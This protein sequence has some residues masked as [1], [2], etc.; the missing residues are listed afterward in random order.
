MRWLIFYFSATKN[1]LRL[2]NFAKEVLT[3]RFDEV[4]L[5]NIEQFVYL[6]ENKL[7][8][9]LPEE[10][11]QKID[12]CDKL[13]FAYPIHAFNAPEIV[14]KWVNSIPFRSNKKSYFILKTAG[15]PMTLNDGS[16]RKI[17]QHLLK[18]NYL[19][20]NE[21][22]YV[23][24]YYIM[25]RHASQVAVKMDQTMKKT[26]PLDLEVIR[27][28]IETKEKVSIGTKVVSSLLRIEQPG[29]H[30]LGK[31]FKVDLTKCI[32][33]GKCLSHCPT[34]NI[35]KVDDKIVFH[36]RC[37]ICMR[38][39]AFCPAKAISIGIMNSWKVEGEYDFSSLVEEKDT[40]A[41]YCKK[42]FAR[43]YQNQEMK[44]QKLLGKK[45]K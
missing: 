10:F 16:S 27:N 32:S 8:Y 38:C 4:E 43:Y 5:V 44:S 13:G 20:Q 18:K 45:E 17:I 42:A 23:M 26:L 7:T 24:P 11:S 19:C 31:H 41:G 39:V 15:E 35:E 34:K 1:T 9:V 25:F 3:Q 33:C 2:V 21:F 12:D 37:L 30:L 22:L 14:E 28:Q 36:H 40:H 29:A 6:S